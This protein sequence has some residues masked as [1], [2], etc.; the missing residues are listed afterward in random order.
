MHAPEPGDFSQTGLAFHRVKKVLMSA[1][2]YPLGDDRAAYLDLTCGHDAILRKQVDELLADEKLKERFLG[3]EF[4]LANQPPSSEQAS[5]ETPPDWIGPYWIVRKIG[6]GGFGE[7]YLGFDDQL[8][9]PVA[10]KVP[11]LKHEV[12]VLP[13]QTDQNDIERKASRER[14]IEQ[15][16]EEF[17]NEA[18]NLA[19]LNHPHIV[20]VY[21]FGR[22]NRFPCYIASQYIE[23]VSLDTYL[24]QSSFS[25]TGAAELVATIAEALHHAHQRGIYHR[26]IKP[27]N[28]F[29]DKQRKPYIGD[30]GLALREED[31]GTGFRYA[32]TPA[33]M[34]PEQARGEGHRVNGCSDIFSLGVVLYELLVGKRPF[35]GSTKSEILEQVEKHD[36]KPPRQQSDQIPREIER[37]CLK[38]LSKK[39]TERYTTAKDLATELRLFLQQPVT[40]AEYAALRLGNQAASAT[41]TLSPSPNLLPGNTRLTADT[42]VPPTFVPVE[43]QPSRIFPKGLRSFNAQDADFFLE[44]LPGPHDREG[45]P[46]SLRFWKTRIEATDPEIT[47][48]VGLIY[49]PSGCGKT[50]LVQAGLLPRLAAEVTVVYLEATAD[51]TEKRLLKGLHKHCD[52]LKKEQG[53]IEVMRSLRRAPERQEGGKV[54]IVLDQ[55][56]QWLHAKRGE[57]NTQ[58]V[59][60]LRQC[61]GER[62]QCLLMVREDF[63]PAAA[64]FMKE[65]EI[66]LI[67]LRNAL[68][69]E[70]FR[71]AHARKV[72]SRFGAAFGQLPQDPSVFN[73]DQRQFVEQAISGLLHDGFVISVRLALFA[74][75]MKERPW[76]PASLLAIGG[77]AGV[78]FTFL[79][80]TF[81]AKTAP[82]E[83]RLHQKAVRAMLKSLL[84]DSGTEIKG[85]MR[86]QAEL[87]AISGYRNRPEQFADVLRILDPELRLLTPTDPE[88]MSNDADQSNPKTDEPQANLSRPDPFYQLTHDYLVPSLRAWLTRK[89]QQTRR[90]RAELRLEERTAIWKNKPERRHLPSIGELLSAWWLVPKN[91][92]TLTQQ[93]MLRKAFRLHAMILGIALIFVFGPGLHY[94][95]LIAKTKLLDMK[96]GFEIENLVRELGNSKGE[97]TRDL[98]Q[99]LKNEN[100]NKSQVILK[101]Q[102]YFANAAKQEK[103]SL[104][105]AL[106]EFGTVNVDYLCSCIEK[107]ESDEINNLV[108]ALGH[109]REQPIQKI[110]ELADQATDDAISETPAEVPKHGE[111]EKYKSMNEQW[112]WKFRLAVIGL[113]LGDTTIA[114]DMCQIQDR[115]DPIQRTLFIDQLPSWHGDLSKIC[116]QARISDDTAFLSAIAC[117]IGRIKQENEDLK[118]DLRGSWIALFN[119]WHKN[120]SDCVLHSSAGWALR[121]WETPKPELTRS[122]VPLTNRNWFINSQEITMIKISTGEFDHKVIDKKTL[123]ET[124]MQHVTISQAYYLS[125]REITVA[126]FQQFVD[127]DNSKIAKPINWRGGNYTMTWVDPDYDLSMENPDYTIH[128]ECANYTANPLGDHPV[129]QVSWYDAVLYC[130]WLSLKTGRRCCYERGGKKEKVTQ[131]NGD[132]QEIK[133]KE[134]DIDVWQFVPNSNGYRLP[135]EREWEYACRAGTST[136]YSCGDQTKFLINYGNYMSCNLI[137]TKKCY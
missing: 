33:Y 23:G 101:L 17:L 43:N 126:Q 120:S 121:Q 16:A 77:T 37:I 107:A 72:L 92:Q 45:L 105:Y 38:A 76:T 111:S 25:P 40:S 68:V 94:W 20:A 98:I 67:E 26:D 97:R 36:P 22:T 115:P 119:D 7:V 39:A 66:R 87:Q 89:Q 61:D 24:K 5:D 116:E 100:F 122:D 84:P 95:N 124:R 53:L 73:A 8:K 18:R 52:G 64:R 58:L 65:L 110:R 117:G 129:R 69:V 132:M 60:A 93:Q 9:R 55:F 44:L 113:H 96:T 2:E 85:H 133:T 131:L 78:G 70:R 109:D 42:P 4:A 63:W 15:L 49:G 127:D 136:R 13:D 82:P 81:S 56:E 71:P 88:G 32:G 10:I 6:Q 48:E 27:A 135:S 57:E 102:T 79:E 90:G 14:E 125:D 59:Q 123:K 41:P 108:T 112:E 35:S 29:L 62:L 114:H 28:L 106:A 104:A 137:K 46:E 118:T 30:F 19:T 103:R 75:M 11:Q 130:N 91:H 51:E 134:F 47:F 12:P 21:N 74:E 31:V 50:S 83:H 99:G 34:S 1:L 128:W 54:L 86:S 80:E 3:G